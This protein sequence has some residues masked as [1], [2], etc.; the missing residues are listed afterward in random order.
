L[1]WRFVFAPGEEEDNEE[2]AELAAELPAT[3]AACDSIL[4]LIRLM[5]A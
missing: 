5:Y 3:L 4:L 1:R 2:E